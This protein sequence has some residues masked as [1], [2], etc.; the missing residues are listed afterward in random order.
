MREHTR[1]GPGKARTDTQQRLSIKGWM[2]LA[3]EAALLVTLSLGGVALAQVSPP[4]HAR[5]ASA[6]PV[7][8]SDEELMKLSA[9]GN[10]AEVELGRLA[11]THSTDPAIQDLGTRLAQD[12]SKGV[13]NLQAVAA[14]VHVQLPQTPAGAEEGQIAQLRQLTALPSMRASSRSRTR[15]RVRCCVSFS[16]E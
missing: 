13:V 9:Q 14:M 7:P 8:R 6:A 15:T 11:I 12:G 16:P 10:I 3:S 4:A 1:Q 5:S 2:S